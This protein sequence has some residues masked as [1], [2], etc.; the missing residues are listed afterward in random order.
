MWD[1]IS[2]L[3]LIR[4]KMT[5][6]QFIVVANREAYTH[7]FAGGGETI[8]CIRPA[9]GMAAALDPLMRASRGTWIGPGSGDADRATVDELDHVSVPPDDPSYTLRRV[10]L[11]R[12]QEEGYYHGMANSGLW[13]LCHVTFTR[14][15]F[16]PDHRCHALQSVRRRRTLRGHPAR[17]G[18]GARRAQTKDAADAGRRAR[19]QCLSLGRQDPVGP[20][21]SRCRRT[22]RGTHHD[23]ASRM[24]C[25]NLELGSALDSKGVLTIC[26]NPRR[27]SA[28]RCCQKDAE[29]VRQFLAWL[30]QI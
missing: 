3:E 27:S 26:V 21:Q 18:D 9:S 7:R 13:P 29:E 14:P 10:W 19:E 8:E 23:H 25:P 6:Y 30:A 16:D 28:A 20:P 24:G 17:A 22:L 12:E 4:N 15:T 2:L 1:K 5:D 11:T